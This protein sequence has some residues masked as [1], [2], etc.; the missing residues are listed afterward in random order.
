V[1]PGTAP[2]RVDTRGTWKLVATSVLLATRYG[3]QTRAPAAT[4]A[5]DGRAG[6]VGSKL[7]VA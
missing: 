6:A 5:T 4:G 2:E 7:P 3:S 1:L